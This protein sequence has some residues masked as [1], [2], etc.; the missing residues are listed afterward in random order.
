M[1]KNRI[2]T[3]LIG[4]VFLMT[5]VV[6]CTPESPPLPPLTGDASST[7]APATKADTLSGDE[8]ASLAAQAAS[9]AQNM[10]QNNPE[11]LDAFARASRV[12]AE[13]ESRMQ[14]S[15]DEASG[16]KLTVTKQGWTGWTP[17]QPEPEVSVYDN[18][19]VGKEMYY[20]IM[21]D[22]CCV[23]IQEVGADYIVV[24]FSYNYFVEPNSNGGIS[25]SGES[26]KTLEV[27]V[28][29]EK[30]VVTQTM[31]AGTYLYFKLEKE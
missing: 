13:A 18:V 12:A 5:A 2:I 27:K 23:T 11:A 3:L 29:E 25:L 14:A 8:K 6:G 16:L 26:L 19:T 4:A 15:M 22:D 20:S 10:M 24:A 7:E 28:G 21:G 30:K 1:K 17:E 31:D 9:A